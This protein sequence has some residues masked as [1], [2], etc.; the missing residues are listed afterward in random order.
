M[1]NT[2]TE[3]MIARARDGDMD[4]FE[5]I[6]RAA[7]GFVYNVALRITRHSSDAEDVTQEVFVKMHRNLKEFRLQ[8]SCKTW[9]YR[10]TVNSALSRCRRLTTEQG[11]MARYRNE[12]EV[13]NSASPDAG[14]KQIGDRRRILDAM[15]SEL[16]PD[17]RACLVM[18][19]MEG[20]AYAEIAEILRVPLNT[21]RSRLHR[22]RKTL[23]AY[24]RKE[25]LV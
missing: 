8:S 20:L 24:A 13:E 19:E 22:A 10:I 12:V 21:V 18:R 11:A 7:S 14:E 2:I 25:A 3:D 15:L 23:M 6:Y 9:L 5:R 4:A 16:E 17:Q 1:E